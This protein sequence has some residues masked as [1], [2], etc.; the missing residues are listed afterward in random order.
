MTSL[1]K[2]DDYVGFTQ[3]Q[4]EFLINRD[5]H[6]CLFR[7]YIDGRWVRCTQSENLH[8]HHV[9]PR[10]W[11]L[12]HL[13]Y[14][15]EVNGPLNAVTLCKFHH[16]GYGAVSGEMEFVVHPDVEPTRMAYSLGNIQAYEQMKERREALVQSGR[17]YWNTE[18]DWY[19]VLAARQMSR[20][21]SGY[22]LHKKFGVIGG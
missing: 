13:P 4:R 11:C 20:G 18:F 3:K 7:Q 12:Y 21:I 5:G 6:Q 22:P 15:F 14:G 2:P 1:E 10:R 9:I 16:V 17:A 19:F 8:I